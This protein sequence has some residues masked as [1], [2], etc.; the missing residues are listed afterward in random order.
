M[1]LPEH[2]HTFL[3]SNEAEDGD[4]EYENVHN[5]DN[6]DDLGMTCLVSKM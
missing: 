5:E 1:T 6:N 2:F 3:D 4:C